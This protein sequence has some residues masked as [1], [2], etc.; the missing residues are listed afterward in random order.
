[1]PTNYVR[2][3]KLNVNLWQ[4]ILIPKKI[5]CTIIQEIQNNITPFEEVIN[6]RFAKDY[7]GKIFQPCLPN[8]LLIIL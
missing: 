5:N 2:I 1:M 8:Q 6:S 4:M 7:L 3:L